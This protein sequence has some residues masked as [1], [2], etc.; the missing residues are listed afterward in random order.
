MATPQQ[1]M[2]QLDPAHRALM[3][4]FSQYLTV[5]AEGFTSPIRD[6]IQQTESEMRAR[7]DAHQQ[8]IEK[9]HKAS[10]ERALDHFRVLD[11]KLQALTTFV[12][13]TQ[14][15]LEISRQAFETRI[16][17]ELSGSLQKE[18]SGLRAEL[19]LVKGNT[20]GLHA[21]LA[22]AKADAATNRK[23]VIYLSVVATLALLVCVFVLF[24]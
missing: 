23:F 16:L 1:K 20:A 21:A 22:S 4:E 24:K 15:S 7:I 2:S 3:D 8:S 9:I 19:D 5:I 6:T 10:A 14:Q 18:T 11:Q 13:N 17:R 12:E